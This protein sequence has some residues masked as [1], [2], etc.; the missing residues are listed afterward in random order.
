MNRV[1]YV[2]LT[3]IWT[4]PLFSADPGGTVGLAK[5][6]FTGSSFDTTSDVMANASGYVLVPEEMYASSLPEKTTVAWAG[7]MRMEAGITYDFK[8]C[9]DDF[10]SVKINGT[11]VLSQGGE[12]KERT[13]SYVPTATDWCPI[14]FRVANNGGGGGCQNASQYGILLKKNSDADWRQVS[15]YD[16]QGVA[17]FKTGRNDLAPVFKTTPIVLS[18]KMREN[19]PT[20]MDVTYIV[21][22]TADT[23]NVR[24]LSFEDGERS[25]W[26]VVRPETFENDPEGNPTVQNIGDNIPANVVHKLAWKVDSDWKTDLAKVK[27]E[28]LT[29]EQGQLPLDWVKIPGVNG[30][31][32]IEVSYNSQTDAD[33]LNALF[34]YYADGAN[35]LTIEDGYLKNAKSIALVSRTYVSDKF[36]AIEHIAD[37]MGLEMFEGTFYHYA[38]GAMRKYFPYSWQVLCRKGMTKVAGSLYIGEKA[39]CVIDVSGGTSAASYPVTYLDSEPIAGWGGEYKTTK[40]LLR[41]IEPGNVTMGGTKPVTLTKPFY[42]G[43]FEI[44]QKQYQLVTGSN[45]SSYKG[46][47]RPVEC[48]SWNDIRGAY[49]WPSVTTVDSATFI[50]KL[51]AKTGLNFDLPTESQWEYACRAGT[52][53]YYNNGGS[54]D[55]DLKQ[56]GRY[57][58]NRTDG[59]GSYSEHTT[60]GSYSPNAWGLYDMHGNVL[61]WCLDWYGGINSYPTTDFSGADSGSYRVLRGGCWNIGSIDAR[62]SYRWDY[63]YRPLYGDTHYGR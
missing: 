40:I 23:V 5:A 14:E 49:N 36:A 33:V 61:E 13:G 56:L 52:T 22:S 15:S 31:P 17:L 48:V 12:C 58:D 53:S 50:G 62:S 16:E 37:K 24:A 51:Q 21:H 10:V 59:R 46:D 29:S 19:A 18:S 39:Y 55:N 30:V 20:I 35:D 8:G 42:M 11:W 6:T 9:Y 3:V 41:R 57:S 43:V 26:K 45:P 4:L 1:C 28:I 32:D 60:V 54:S 63:H 38:V 27:F 47:M 34:W 44:T 25:F 7:Y 2:A